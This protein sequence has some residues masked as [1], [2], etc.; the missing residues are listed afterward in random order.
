[1]N[2]G[3]PPTARNAR[4]GE[5]YAAGEELLGALVERLGMGVLWGANFGA[6]DFGGPTL[7]GHDGFSIE[8]CGGA[9]D[10]LSRAESSAAIRGA[11]AN[12]MELEAGFYCALRFLAAA[13]LNGEDNAGDFK[14]DGDAEDYAAEKVVPICA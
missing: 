14:D 2:G 8:G 10:A 3:E 11:I 5:F 6:P 9:A 4:T 13:A 12:W 7:G 1:M